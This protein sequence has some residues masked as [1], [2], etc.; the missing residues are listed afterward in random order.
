MIKRGNRRG[1]REIE[2]GEVVIEKEIEDREGG[3]VVIERE[4]EEE[5]GEGGG[6]ETR[7]FGGVDIAVS[8]EIVN[9]V[10]LFLYKGSELCY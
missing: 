5:E 9:E 2:G 6:K 3:E 4:I 7:E 8:A 1:D 10:L